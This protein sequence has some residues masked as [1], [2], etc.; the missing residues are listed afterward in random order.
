LGLGSAVQGALQDLAAGPSGNH[1]TVIIGE[2]Y[3][4]KTTV[5]N[6]LLGQPVVPVGAAGLRTTTRIRAGDGWRAV[7]ETG[8]EVACGEPLALKGEGTTTLLV[9]GPAPILRHTTLVDTPGLN[10]L[11]PSFDDV[12][13]RAVLGAD[14]VLVCISAS[15]HLAETERIF[16]RRR[17]L[18]V[19]AGE[20]VLVIT[21][22]DQL[23]S[24]RDRQ[25]IERR[26]A[27]FCQQAGGRLQA[28]FA[29]PG[30]A[31]PIPELDTLLQTAAT[32]FNNGREEAWRAKVRSL[33]VALEHVVQAMPQSAATAS[34]AGSGFSADD[35]VTV[36]EQEHTLA[37]D[38]ARAHLR[39]RFAD[40]RVALPDR[41]ARLSPDVLQ[42]EGPAS[43]VGDTQALGREVGRIY[44]QALSRGLTLGAPHAVQ[45]AAEGLQETTL[46]YAE[47]AIRGGPPPVA[48]AAKRQPRDRKLVLLTALGAGL[49]LVSGGAATPLVGGGL[50]LFAAHGL[51]QRR[52]TAL[53][54][55]LRIDAAAA[56][57]EWLDQEE[58]ELAL[59]LRAACKPVLEGLKDR[60]RDLVTPPKRAS[61]TVGTM[62]AVVS[63]L[64]IC[65]D[66]VNADNAPRTALV[67]DE[68]PEP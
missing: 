35:L 51:R 29:P 5:A 45:K 36:V 48:S 32:R 24:D 41:L 3:R 47:A 18:P 11:D 54:E 66:L 42:H 34:T 67:V 21:F 7:D 55:R 23:E 22:L 56:A 33:L 49:I 25:D 50:A 59:R 65:L 14:V 12:V 37:L 13:I 53:A 61:E 19:A 20:V 6:R 1:E 64:H 16:I 27:R 8:A 62:E 46:G 44:L 4:G 40:L 15:Q 58:E 2:K 9:E 38:E 60:V 30:T 39:A 52:D 57:A 68:R 28:V 26:T 43:L 17:I 63:Q 10:D 31:S